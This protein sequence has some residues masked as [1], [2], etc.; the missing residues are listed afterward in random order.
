MTYT[1][2]ADVYLGDVS[3]QVYEFLQ[4][5]RAAIF[6]KSHAVDWQN[7]PDYQ[8]WHNGPVI[9][10]VSD[11][12]PLLDRWPAVA[13]EYKAAQQRLFA[14]TIDMT[15]EAASVRGARAIAEYV[16]NL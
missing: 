16:R 5:P 13:A 3:S 4:R 12:E 6:L 7:H 9:D 14:Y 8:F 2:A 1:R 10:R 15:D 11:L